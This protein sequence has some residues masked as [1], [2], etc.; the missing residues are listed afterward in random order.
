METSEIASK[1]PR[2]DKIAVNHTVVQPIVQAPPTAPVTPRESEGG[3]K[4]WSKAEA[5]KLTWLQREHT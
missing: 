1:I 3:A 4:T 2:W 5:L